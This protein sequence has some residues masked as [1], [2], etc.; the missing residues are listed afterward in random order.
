MES[1]LPDW[2]APLEEQWSDPLLPAVG[3]A[4][5]AWSYELLPLERVLSIPPELQGSGHW[6]LMAPA[7]EEHWKEPDLPW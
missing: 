2:V 1:E 6:E 3:P 7:E 4:S 5:E